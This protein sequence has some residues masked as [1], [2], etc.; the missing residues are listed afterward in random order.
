MEVYQKDYDLIVV[1]GGGSALTAAAVASD[2]GAKVILVSKDPIGCSDTKISEGGITVQGSGDAD[3]SVQALYNNIRIRGNDLGDIEITKAFV[4]ESRGAYQWL[5]R[6][7]IRPFFRRDGSGPETYPTAVG[8]H[9]R[10]RAIPHANGGLSFIHPLLAVLQDTGYDHFQD[11]WFLDLIL[12]EDRDAVRRV[13]GGLVYLAGKG[14]L[15]AI[16]ARAV[17]LATG[18]ASTL[19]F[20]NTDTMGGNTG[21]GYAVALRAGASLVDM[22]QVQ[23][24]PFAL[25]RPRSMRGLF[26]GEPVCAGPLGV[27]RD[28]NHHVLLTG[29]M[30]RTRSDISGVMGRAVAS[31]LGTASGGCFLDLTENMRGPSGAV[32]YRLFKQQMGRQLK[33]VL[34]AMGAPAA[35][36]EVPWEVQPSAHYFMGGILV[37]PDGRSS[38]QGAVKGLFAAG[39]TMGGLHGSERLGGNSLSEV[40]IFGR[41]AGQAAADYAK[42]LEPVGKQAFFQLSRETAGYY[43][44]MIG[45][46]GPYRPAHL[47]GEL[48]KAAWENIGPARS[49]R[50]MASLL[51]VIGRIRTGLSHT[52]IGAGTVWNQEFIDQVEL[53]NLLDSAEAIT[54]SAL[55]RETSLG[56]HYILDSKRRQPQRMSLFSACVSRK[57]GK[58]TL[59]RLPRQHS[60]LKD[61]GKD[62]L[63]TKLRHGCL[64]FLRRCPHPIQDRILNRV[65][66]RLVP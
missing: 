10:A 30:F 54:H 18:G 34:R 28:R 45:R 60:A 63:M 31:G 44:G 19:Y 50:G 22:E 43:L 32:Y 51:E 26:V 16:R 17:L 65:Y 21:D 66:E 20:P 11:A 27:L 62:L 35:R 56:S 55:S 57:G 46:E 38:G 29:L 49:N 33:L 7:G 3:D 48:Q 39:Q 37:D 9:D 40:L 47:K 23:F 1:G 5:R 61:K 53:E 41:R 64:D 24:I 52:R 8:G 25:T 6:Q 59:S 36:L 42:G 2:T 58:W 13:A 12:A 4:D 14:V 15:L